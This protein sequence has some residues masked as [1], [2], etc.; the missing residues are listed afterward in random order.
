MTTAQ[1]ATLAGAEQTSNKGAANGYQPLNADGDAEFDNLLLPSGTASELDGIVPDATSLH[2]DTDALSL[3]TGLSSLS[4]GVFIG[5]AGPALKVAPDCRTPT[6]SGTRMMALYDALKSATPGGSALSEDNPAILALLP[7]VTYQVPA[8]DA[9]DAS[10]IHVQGLGGTLPIVQSTVT[11]L[12]TIGNASVPITTEFRRLRFVQTNAA[13]ASC[14][15]V[16]D[17]C[18][19]LTF[20]DCFFGL[21]STTQP[22]CVPFS[23]TGSLTLIARRCRTLGVSLF[24]GRNTW[25][26][27]AASL[28]VDCEGGNNSFGS[29]TST[30][31]GE[32]PGTLISCRMFGTSWNIKPNGTCVMDHVKTKAAISRLVA[33]AKF[34]DCIFDPSSGAALNNNSSAVAIK[35]RGHKCSGALL[36]TN[37]TNDW[38]SDESMG[39]GIW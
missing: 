3:R 33:G 18:T 37:V 26:F 35:S 5:V 2:L 19:K 13:V 25:T 32:F 1:K 39:S 23:G 21:T 28:M 4:G 36:G 10:H 14:I 12:L 30:S 24:G 8:S 15:P 9:W 34:L 16:A 20:E 29:G 22:A 31:M 6:A 11:E 17:G 27:N 38:S 7:G